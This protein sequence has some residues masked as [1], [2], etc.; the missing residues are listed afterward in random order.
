[1]SKFFLSVP[2]MMVQ[3]KEGK[4]P[5]EDSPPAGRLHYPVKFQLD[6]HASL[7][8]CKSLGGN[9]EASGLFILQY[10][11]FHKVKVSHPPGMCTV[12]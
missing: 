2:M 11:V 9:S 4:C 6:E 3:H 5:A 8:K 12:Q 7:S 10:A 1:M